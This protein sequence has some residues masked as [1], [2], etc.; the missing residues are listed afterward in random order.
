MLGTALNYSRC[1]D[2]WVSVIKYPRGQLS[3]R[4]GC[5]ASY[6]LYILESI[7]IMLQE[8]H[9]HMDK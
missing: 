1:M 3:Y 9:D 8:N 2:T 4:F 6:Q 7:V 5:R